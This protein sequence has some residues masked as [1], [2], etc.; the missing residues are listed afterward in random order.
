MSTLLVVNPRKQRKTF[1]LQRLRCG[2]VQRRPC[3][4]RKHVNLNACNEKHSIYNDFVV[5]VNVIGR[6]PLQRKT[7]NLQRLR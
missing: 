4:G 1:N 3:I 6:K 5:H 7:F 2:H